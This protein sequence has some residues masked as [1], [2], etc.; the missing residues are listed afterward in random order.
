MSN[1]SSRVSR[2]LWVLAFAPS[3]PLDSTE[4]SFP[5]APV[6]LLEIVK[7]LVSP[8]PETD[9]DVFGARPDPAV[10]IFLK[11]RLLG[12]GVLVILAGHVLHARHAD[13]N[14]SAWLKRPTTF[15]EKPNPLL[16]RDMLQKVFAVYECTGVVGDGQPSGYI[17]AGGVPQV[18]RRPS[19]AMIAHEPIGPWYKVFSSAKAA[20]RA[21]QI[22]RA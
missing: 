10:S 9:V 5:Q 11:P 6:K 13:S 1:V 4:S 7:P 16:D 17:P 12:P 21:G 19:P 14:D 15:D 8:V 20:T 3:G 18:A 2:L 22:G